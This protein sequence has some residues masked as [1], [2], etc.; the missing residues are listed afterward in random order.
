MSRAGQ[1]VIIMA[2]FAV[3]YLAGRGKLHCLRAGSFEAVMAC[4]RA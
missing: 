4:L 3:L 1:V 2:A